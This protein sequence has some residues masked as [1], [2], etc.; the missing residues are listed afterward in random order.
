MRSVQKGFV[1]IIIIITLFIGIITGINLIYKNR[2]TSTGTRAVIQQNNPIATN[3]TPSAISE[4]YLD[5]T[6][7]PLVFEKI[8]TSQYLNESLN[9]KIYA[10]KKYGYTIKY[11][12][13]WIHSLDFCGGP[14]RS[15]CLDNQ[16]FSESD[17]YPFDDKYVSVFI[18]IYE[19]ENSEISEFLSGGSQYNDKFTVLSLL[20]VNEI[21]MIVSVSNKGYTSANND[22]VAEYSLVADL[23]SPQNKHLTI[24]YGWPTYTPEIKPTKAEIDQN[25]TFFNQILS[26]FKLN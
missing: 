16:E 9:W 13:N 10:S 26:T 19:Y 14:D 5:V 18:D 22:E 7:P 1:S 12:S 24:T 11:P 8:D 3:P 4:N 25:L 2:K 21:P 23:I 15:G 6:P 17:N 20:S